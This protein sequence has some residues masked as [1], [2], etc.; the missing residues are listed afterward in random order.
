MS[1]PV[2]ELTEEMLLGDEAEQ[3]P[4]N[5][6][7]LV[8]HGDTQVSREDKENDKRIR[9]AQKYIGNIAIECDK[10]LGQHMRTTDIVRT[11]IWAAVQQQTRLASEGVRNIMQQIAN[12]LRITKGRPGAQ[13]MNEDLKKILEIAQLTESEQMELFLDSS[14]KNSENL[15]NLCVLLECEQD[16]LTQKCLAMKQLI[17][18]QEETIRD[19]QTQ[20]ELLQ[21]A[22]LTRRVQNMGNRDASRAK[23]TNVGEYMGSSKEARWQKFR[24]IGQA[25]SFQPHQTQCCSNCS[26]HVYCGRPLSA[27]YEAKKDAESMLATGRLNCDIQKGNVDIP[28][29]SN[30]DPVVEY[31]KLSA[32]PEVS[33]FHGNEKESFN[34]FVNAFSVKYP[35]S[36][37]DDRSRVQLFEGFLRK[38]AL[39]MFE[40][41]PKAVKDG[42]FEVVVEAMKQRLKVDSNGSCVKAMTQLAALTIREGQSVAEF[43]LVL[44]KLAGRAYPDIPPEI[45]SLQKAEILFRQLASWEGSYCIVEA[46]ETSSRDEVYEKVKEVALRLERNR[47]MAS[48]MSQPPKHLTRLPH[49]KRKFLDKSP[50]KFEPSRPRHQAVATEDAGPSKADTIRKEPSPK[51]SVGS[52]AEEPAT[53]QCYEPAT[54]QCYKCGKRGHKARDCRETASSNTLNRSEGRQTGSFSAFLD[55]VL[56]T[57]S[58]SSAVDP[59]RELF[60]QKSVVIVELMGMQ[61]ESLQD[62]GSETSIIP[63]ALFK[64]AREYKVDLDKYVERIPTV[65]AVIRNAS[66]EQMRFVDT[67][68]MEVGLNGRKNLVAFH[69][70]GG[71]DR[72]VILG[73]NA[74]ETFG[75]QLTDMT[76][77]PFHC[78][79]QVCTGKKKILKPLRG[80]EQW[81][82]QGAIYLRDL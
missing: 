65:D 78:L 39:T 77:Q 80:S 75:I 7:A 58:V 71:L 35:S 81:Y 68:R 33:P 4:E 1:L 42:P 36:I 22:D 59:A 23:P 29:G 13:S 5:Q 28:S 51:Q 14:M 57:S 43:C 20:I 15:Q 55:S 69:V 10:I 61:V 47:K 11:E 21:M 18:D 62:T 50:R 45:V 52:S 82:L 41:L 2:D 27:S 9:M 56:C 3:Q 8:E 6:E 72:M 70:G 38:D 54:I 34:R 30:H 16:E 49:T 40:T 63:L 60:G 37:W 17:L 79:M 32:L 64:F 74:L 46:I 19:M 67:I 24:N 26:T 73:T 53:I 12:E 66:G 25:P 31:M 48:N 44:E 76:G